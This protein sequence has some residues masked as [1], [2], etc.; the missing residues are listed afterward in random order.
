MKTSRASD[1]SGPEVV[2]K[3]NPRLVYARLTGFGQSGPY[4]DMAGHDI[5]YLALSGVL[6]S[7]GRKHENP[8]APSKGETS[9]SRK[10]F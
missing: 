3:E 7:L 6:N 4:K 9:S 5:N 8:L 10:L 1:F 2:T